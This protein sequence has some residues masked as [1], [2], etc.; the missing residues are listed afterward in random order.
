MLRCVMDEGRLAVGALRGVAGAMSMTGARTLAAELGLLSHGTPPE[1]MADE[2]L[3]PVMAAVPEALRPAVVD[4]LHLGYGALG[5]A[6]YATVLPVTWRRHWAGGPVFGS[7]LWLAYNLGLVPALR[8]NRDQ[9][10]RPH[11]IAVLAA[12]HLLYGLMIGHLGGPPD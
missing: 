4:L 6:V 2:A 10:R 3:A 8:L 7:A 9:P 11:E 5:G 12:D 1:K